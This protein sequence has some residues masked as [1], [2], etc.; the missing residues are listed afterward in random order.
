MKKEI[1]RCMGCMSEK[2]YSGPCEICGYSD[3]DAQE[4]DHLGPK[5]LLAD[6]YVVGRLISKGGEGNVYL[7]F[8][9]KLEKA[10]EIKEFMPDTL[11]IR[12][13]DHESVEII[14]GCLP[15]FKSYLSEYADLHKTL[16][17]GFENG[18]VTKTYEI[19]AANGTGYVVT[20]HAD[21]VTLGEYLA[22]N[23]GMLSWG[24]ASRLLP[25]LF[26]TLS[27]MHDKGIVHR[28]LSPE[29]IIITPDGRPVI[30]SV[31]ISA[32]RT[33][34]SRISCEMF[35]G[36]AAFEQYDLSERQGGW[37][38]VYGM[39]AVIYRMVTGLIPQAANERKQHDELKPAVK[40]NPD[41]PQYVSDAISDGMKLGRTE[42][43]HDIKTLRARLYD[44]PKEQENVSA[45]DED[46]GPITPAVHVKFD[47]EEQEEQRRAAAKKKRKKKEERKNIGSAVGLIIFLALVAALVICIIYFSEESQSISTNT[48][49]AGTTEHTVAIE[50]EPE[51]TTTARTIPEE[52]TRSTESAGDKLVLPDFVG[53]FYND[54]LRSRYSMLT[55][56]A[57]EEYNSDFSEGI[58]M[59]QDIPEGTKVSSG[60]VIH[61]KVSKGAAY[62]FLPDYVGMKLSD[63]TQKLTTLGVRFET[64]PEESSEVKQGYVVRCSKNVGDKVYISQNEG[65]TVYYAVTP[66][67]TTTEAPETTTTTAAPPEETTTKKTKKTT[68]APEEAPEDTDEYS[69][70][71]IT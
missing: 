64:V 50:E 52:T 7:A 29:T 70:E 34:D 1:N 49:T 38:D 40:M 5:T 43:L 42:R 46:D 13:A 33:A 4:A 54:T 28:G 61:I 8:D 15:L 23:G 12:S 69:G 16:M 20:E 55:F 36:F 6:R 45:D 39:S 24:E 22:Q 44:A 66:T 27:A 62:T 48:V 21:G 17:T 9:T 18:G 47:I 14:D 31:E 2:L 37:T 60:A 57:E 53:R 67:V 58:I 68:K 71:V 11:C 3:E 19:F 59:E 26:D 63:Y 32:A 25:P 65:V 35:G 10:V 56:E 30:T 51:V 41:V